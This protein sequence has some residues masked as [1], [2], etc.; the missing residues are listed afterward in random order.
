MRMLA[1]AL[2][3]LGCG[4]GD[5]GG[6]DRSGPQPQPATLGE[7]CDVILDAICARGPECVDGFNY[8]ACFQA[9]KAACCVDDGTCLV[10]YAQDADVW[11]CAEALDDYSCENLDNGI[12]PAVCSMNL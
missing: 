3:V 12:L 6:N 4:G 7:A 2:V 1:T 11:A 8:D 9:A 10:T 5:D